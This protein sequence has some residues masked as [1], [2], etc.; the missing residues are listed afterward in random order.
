M[1]Y[2]GVVQT[3]SFLSM[4]LFLFVGAQQVMSGEMTIGAMV[5]FNS[6]VAM[7]NAPI[8]TLLSMWD[9]W[10][11]AAVLLNRMNDIFESEPEQ[12]FDHSHLKPVRAL[13]GL[14]R[15]QGVS[16]QYGGR[17]RRRF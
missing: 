15:L 5:A 7:A 10:Q 6:L 14:V 13:E 11:L 12:G 4:A 9:N 8:L 2:E 1:S 3:V 16:F 17:I